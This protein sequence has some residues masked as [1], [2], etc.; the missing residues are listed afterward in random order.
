MTCAEWRWA[1]VFDVAISG[2]YVLIR[3]QATTYQ[4]LFFFP[5]PNE[6]TAMVLLEGCELDDKE[7]HPMLTR[8][9]SPHPIMP[10]PEH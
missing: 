8:Q 9:V 3:T 7:L 1:G 2:M 6:Q 5:P 10:I 4:T